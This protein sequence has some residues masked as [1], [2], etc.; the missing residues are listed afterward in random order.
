V[1]RQ[2]DFDVLVI[3]GGIV[4]LATAYKISKN[5]PDLAVAV[6]EKENQIGLHQTGHNSGVIHSGIYYQPGSNKARTCVRGRKELVNFA[7][8][9]GI[10]HKI[11]G[12]IIVAT[13]KKELQCL[14]RVFQNGKNN[15]IEGLEKIGPAEIKEI[16]PLCRGIAGL[17]V[18][19]TG[20]IDFRRVCE[21]LAKL[22]T[23]ISDHNQILLSHEVVG[24]ERHDFFT[25]VITRKEELKA[26]CIINCAGLQ[27]DRIARM[28]EVKSNIKIVPFR[29]DYYALSQEAAQKVKALIYPVPDTVFPFLGIH[30]TRGFDG[31]VE[32]GPN[33]VFSFKREGYGKASFSF[34]DS[35]ESLTYPGTWK[36]F[37]KHI[38]YGISEY[39][40]AFSM[41]LFTEH[42]QRLIPTIRTEDIKYS[43]SG[44]R[45]QAV[46][47][48]GQIIDDFE[49]RINK[50]VIHVLNAPSP[51]ATASLAIG[52]HI[53]EVAEKHFDFND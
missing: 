50:N 47:R 21:K 24:L 32:C 41:D 35:W 38:R 13:R 10:P 48:A 18:S 12:K 23:R 1:V 51:A 45:A 4:G 39:S 27:S 5:H 9:H 22:I 11:C 40:K 37:L 25:S 6:V 49:I 30:F 2:F 34:K 36:L 17:K 8:K 46:D 52:E 28:D 43:K 20:V 29:G 16:E 14:E 33:A 31:Q 53:R 3:G 7:A 42:I 44:I 19:C 26:T 15:G